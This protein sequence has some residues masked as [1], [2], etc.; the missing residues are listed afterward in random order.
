[1][2]LIGRCLRA[3]HFFFYLGLGTPVFPFMI[4]MYIKGKQKAKLRRL[5]VLLLLFFSDDRYHGVTNS[6]S[7]TLFVNVCKYVGSWVEETN[8]WS[9]TP[10][11]GS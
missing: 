3:D 8:A 5:L 1:M 10:P 4:M 7:R 6:D 2:T 11:L 9:E